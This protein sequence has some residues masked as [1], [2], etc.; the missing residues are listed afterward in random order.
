MKLQHVRYFLKLFELN[1][2]GEAAREC[3]IAQPTL[4]M[5]IKRLE[6][7]LGGALFQPRPVRPTPLAEHL[8]SS[9]NELH[10]KS[11]AVEREAKRFR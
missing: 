2:F 9:L 3:G 4:S 10:L 7:E 5:A 8:H 6:L 1:S 11:Q